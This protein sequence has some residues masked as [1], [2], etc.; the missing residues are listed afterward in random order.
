MRPPI[1]L[2]GIQNAAD[3]IV[4]P[5]FNRSQASRNITATMPGSQI[6]SQIDSQDF[7]E[8]NAN[9]TKSEEEPDDSQQ[10][11]MTDMPCTDRAHQ[12]PR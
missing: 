12:Q 1:T 5:P 10:H 11:G 6:T 2:S 9:E 3:N 8:F 4:P 7:N